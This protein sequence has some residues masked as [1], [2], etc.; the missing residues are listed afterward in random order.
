MGSAATSW[1]GSGTVVLLRVLLQWLYSG[2]TVGPQWLYSG[3]TVAHQ[4]SEYFPEIQ[5]NSSKSEYFPDQE[6]ARSAR[7]RSE[8]A[9]NPYGV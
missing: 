3:A 8:S 2:F 5:E 9:S 6:S 4:K 7:C 1:V